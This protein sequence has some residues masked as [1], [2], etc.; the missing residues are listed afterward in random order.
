MSVPAVRR[1]SE[2]SARSR[3]TLFS[4]AAL[5]VVLAGLLVGPSVV[6][7]LGLPIASD[8]PRV[9]GSTST[10]PLQM[11]FA[12]KRL[13]LACTWGDPAP[14]TIERQVR[15]DTGGVLSVLT[16]GPARRLQSLQHTGTNQSYMRLISGDTDLILVAR[17]PSEDEAKAAQQAGVTLDAKPV[18][19]DAFVFLLH[20]LNTDSNL[21]LEQVRGIYGGKLTNWKQVGGTIPST[22][23]DDSGEIHAYRRDRNSG[24]QELMESLVMKGE[25]MAGLPSMPDTRVVKSMDGMIRTVN[26]DPNA[27]GF[28]VYYYASYMIQAENVRLASIEGVY[29]SAGSIANRTYPLVSD[30]YAVTRADTPATHPAIELRDW[31]LTPEGQAIVA[32]SGYVPL[33]SGG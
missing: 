18:A 27:I 7:G 24:S 13:G 30:V 22:Q 19:L 17:L 29:P 11:L 33:G 31:M 10:Q 5:V 1:L 9:D 16:L 15:A 3:A 2:L 32:A 14:G 20:R 28:I 25:P 23:D 21:T 26:W 4:F 8:Y 12:C 6:L